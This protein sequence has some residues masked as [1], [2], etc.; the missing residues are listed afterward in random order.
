MVH[1]RAFDWWHRRALVEIPT[2][3]TM[4]IGPSAFHPREKTLGCAQIC[5]FTTRMSS[6]ATVMDLA[7]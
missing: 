3:S 2:T 4:N 1:V 6:A 7:V 5:I